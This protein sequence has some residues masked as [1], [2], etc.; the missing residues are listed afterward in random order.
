VFFTLHD[1]PHI[2]DDHEE[3]YHEDKKMT[4]A[5]YERVLAANSVLAAHSKEHLRHEHGRGH[6]ARGEG[7]IREKGNASP[8]GRGN[9]SPLAPTSSDAER[10]GRHGHSSGS[11]GS[12]GSVSERK[13]SARSKIQMPT[14]DTLEL[15]KAHTHVERNLFGKEN[16]F[17][18]R[19]DFG[20]RKQREVVPDTDGSI[21]YVMTC[22][23]LNV[24]PIPVFIG[25][26]ND[27]FVFMRHCA[28]GPR[29]G[30]AIGQSLSLNSR[31]IN[32]DLSFCEIGSDG[33]TALSV[34]LN[35]KAF[36]RS[37]DL[38]ANR[39]GNGGAEALASC[40]VERF[41]LSHLSRL[42]LGS[43]HLADKGAATVA[44][45]LNALLHLDFLDLSSNEIGY[46]GAVALGRAL[47]QHTDEIP[48]N[49]GM[50]AGAPHGKDAKNDEAGAAKP[51][52]N[53]PSKP[54][55]L[56]G[57]LHLDMS[58]N[59]LSNNGTRALCTGLFKNKRLQ[60]L[61]LAHN[62]I[63]NEGANAI[64]ELMIFNDAMTH[65]D[66]SHNRISGIG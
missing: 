47:E 49:S 40:L 52:H 48:Q 24:A 44:R 30:R 36:Y 65:L 50:P 57:L 61:L 60:T 13:L 64:A 4:G 45:I 3:D 58:G 62:N 14:V 31:P 10:G 39:M 11:P 16:F 28:V 8:F 18:F 6:S 21:S 55:V 23:E 46:D 15:I 33:V 27:E 26:I 2:L 66:I 43:N 53:I 63:R 41:K 56:G 22:R 25:Q 7:Q 38:T 17:T 9:A 51:K 32:V 29:G 35:Q 34:G 1:D 19:K 59:Q 37:L 12:K 5:E 54:K 20:L 42:M